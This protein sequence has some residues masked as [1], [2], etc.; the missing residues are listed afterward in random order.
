M[1]ITA[2]V[3]ATTSAPTIRQRSIVTRSVKHE[4]IYPTA[5]Y[6]TQPL[7]PVLKDIEGQDWR[8]GDQ[9]RLRNIAELMTMAQDY[10][11]GSG[12]R[13]GLNRM[14]AIG[15]LG[16]ALEAWE[17]TWHFSKLAVAISV[18]TVNGMFDAG[19]DSG[20]RAAFKS[21]NSISAIHQYLISIITIPESGVG[22]GTSDHSCDPPQGEGGLS[23]ILEYTSARELITH[24]ALPS[25][26][27]LPGYGVLQC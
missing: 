22:T 19:I 3:L 21:L 1:I 7:D 15:K 25:N 9:L 20:N 8:F 16:F 4:L 6:R 14:Q 24:N 23:R 13:I 18:S 27:I 10:L 5:D 12:E 11:T 17:R 2:I 26:I